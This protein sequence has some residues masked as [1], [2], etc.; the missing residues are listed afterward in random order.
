MTVLAII[1]GAAVGA[2]L[3]YTIDRW[4]HGRTAGASDTTGGRGRWRMVP[5]GLFT[6]NVAG[7]GIAGLVLATTSG[8]LRILLLSGFC[9]AF[10]TFSGF[11]WD[12]SLLWSAARTQFWVTVIGMPV[13]CIAAF[14]AVWHLASA[15]GR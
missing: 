11:G 14:M 5:W 10:T 3:R 12:A 9:G 8:D 13:A 6:V 2:P 7:S 4:V 15:A 1:I